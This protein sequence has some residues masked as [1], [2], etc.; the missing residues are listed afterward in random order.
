M[1]HPL[2]VDGFVPN[3]PSPALLSPDTGDPNRFE[4][5]VDTGN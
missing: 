5:C 4:F 3:N 2:K 1:E